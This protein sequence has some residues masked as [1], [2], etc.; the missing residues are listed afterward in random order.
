MEVGNLRRLKEYYF[1]KDTSSSL[2]PN[3]YNKLFRV[4]RIL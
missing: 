3:I 2:K 1:P 4:L